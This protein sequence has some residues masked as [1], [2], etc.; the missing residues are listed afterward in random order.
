MPNVND[1]FGWFSQM[2]P[3]SNLDFTQTDFV[4]MTNKMLELLHTTSKKI[5]HFDKSSMHAAFEIL[6]EHYLAEIQ[7]INNTKYPPTSPRRNGQGK[8]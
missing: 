6:M 4:N 2:Q 1:P 3:S 7:I 8:A 5:G